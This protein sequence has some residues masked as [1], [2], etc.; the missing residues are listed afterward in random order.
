M[1]RLS[2]DP[3]LGSYWIVFGILV[4]LVAILIRFKL[5]GERLSNRGGRILFVLRVLALLF[6]VFAMLRPALVYTKTLRL[7]STLYILIDQSESM[8]RTDEI[9]GNSRFQVAM[10]SLI[11]SE[12]RLKKLEENTEIQCFA[13]DGGVHPL[14][15]QKGS[16]ENLS[17]Q[18]L[19]KETALGHALEEIR[20][21]STGKRVLGTIL[22]SD[23][24]QRTRPPRDI[25]PRDAALRFRDSGIPIFSVRL[26]Q[27]SGIPEVQDI[28]ISDLQANDQVFVKND[29][30]ING[31][32]R[33]SG[34]TNQPIPVQL[35]FE[36]ETG[37]MQ[38]V[39]EK[40]VRATNNGQIL[41]YRFSYTPQKTGY[42]KYTVLVPPQPKELVDTN[43]QQSHFVRV[44]DGG[45]NVLFIQGDPLPELGLL[46]QSL[47]ASADIK[48]QY[49]SLPI[50]RIRADRTSGR[51]SLQQRLEQ[52]T[53]KRPS[54]IDEFVP[55][56]YNVYILDSID[57]TAFKPEELQA[58]ADLVRNGT[59]LIMLGGVHSFGA[60]GYAE[61][62]LAE[63]APV[64]LRIIDRQILGAPVRRDVHWNDPISMLPV[65]EQT[66]RIPYVM[67]LDP[68]SQRNLDIWRSLP[69][70]LGANRFDSLKPAATVLAEGPE[71]Q[72]L[73]V[74]HFYG[75]GRVLAFAGDSTYRWRLAGF[76]EEHKRF[77]RQI[78]LW[79]ARMEDAMEGD[80]WITLDN[81]RLFPGETAR[82][83]VFMKSTDGDVIRNFKALATVVKP[84][85]SDENIV[86]IDEEGI[87]TGSFRSTEQ[88]GDYKI[89]IEAVVDNKQTEP[90]SRTANARFMVYDSNLEL[91][92]PIAYPKLLDNISDLSGGRSIA[93]EQLPD[94]IQELYEKSNE[95]IEPRETKQTLYDNWF[96]LSAFVLV[97]GIEWFLRKRLGLV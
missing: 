14:S 23:G 93:P 64:E 38:F 39:E 20:K 87:P 84:D 58:L 97:L 11:A 34:Y 86:L 18:P 13:F 16:I 91:D 40:T 83:Q 24:N 78:V 73:L 70:L 90:V 17:E 50:G 42:F 3:I 80:C 61:T 63:V 74:S 9:N 31:S 33:I 43:N 82:F 68:N 54:W 52:E 51:Q 21:K 62:P 53:A 75:L 81:V 7:A 96:V 72:R 71:K 79:L 55:D 41:P 26:G 88:S 94:L 57:A 1:F 85:G 29:L 10:E 44:I 27:A 2:F 30:S 8:S 92:N 45:L 56:K 76:G 65:T 36:D 28:A 95:L 59:G 12:P 69:P 25:L 49:R 4:F 32:I 67:R 47:N 66:G 77:W 15:V 35:H 37:K 46:R 48:V 22:L 19:G 5:S 60:G 89:R 6:L